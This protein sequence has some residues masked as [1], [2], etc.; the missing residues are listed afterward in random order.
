MHIYALGVC[1]NKSSVLQFLLRV[2]I[3]SIPLSFSLFSLSPYLSLS[4]S[5]SSLCFFVSLSWREL[6][7]ERSMRMMFVESHCVALTFNDGILRIALFWSWWHEIIRDKR[8]RFRRVHRDDCVVPSRSLSF[9][10]LFLLHRFNVICRERWRFED[11]FA[12]KTKSKA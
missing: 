10:T 6:A 12:R 8:K 1:R 5:L 3:C 11:D 4:I 2:H 7:I 9:K